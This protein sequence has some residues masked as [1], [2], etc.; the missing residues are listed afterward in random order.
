[1]RAG[2]CARPGGAKIEEDVIRWFWG[3][4]LPL[5]EMYASTEAMCITF[6]MPSS[7]KIGTPGIVRQFAGDPLP[8]AAAAPPPLLARALHVFMP[9]PSLVCIVCNTRYLR[10]GHLMRTV[11]SRSSRLRRMAR[12]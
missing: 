10:T 2:T 6:N 12:S 8:A 1:M 11:R 4:G 9:A 3:A 5:Y 7:F